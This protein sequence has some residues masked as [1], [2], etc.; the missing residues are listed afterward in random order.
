MMERILG[1]FHKR[2]GRKARKD[3][4]YLLPGSKR[5]NRQRRRRD[6]A[7]AIIVGVLVCAT[8]V[9]LFWYMNQR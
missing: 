8:M 9:W 4:Y 2:E 1:L 6:V 3:L 5:A 7:V